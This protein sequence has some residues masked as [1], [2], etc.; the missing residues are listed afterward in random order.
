M[1]AVISVVTG[2][3]TKSIHN[4]TKLDLSHSSVYFEFSHFYFLFIP[5]G[6][7]SWLPVSFL[8]LVKYTLSYRIV[9]LQWPLTNPVPWQ[10]WTAVYLDYTQRMKT[11]FCGWPILVHNT[12]TRRRSDQWLSRHFYDSAVT[13]ASLSVAPHI[14]RVILSKQWHWSTHWD[15]TNQVRH[16]PAE[17]LKVMRA[18]PLPAT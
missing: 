11:L 17:S 8:L 16:I 9:S 10:N 14:H 1:T 15:L 12:H 2:S 7:Q 3:T 4:G 6:R 5:C 18:L 13:L